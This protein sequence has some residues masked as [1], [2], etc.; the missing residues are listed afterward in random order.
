MNINFLGKTLTCEFRN[1]TGLDIEFC[2]SRPVWAIP[3]GTEEVQ[4]YPFKGTV[5]LLPFLVITWGYVYE[6]I[7]E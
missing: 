3:E 5:V 7:G 2:S 4:C 1:G 6:V